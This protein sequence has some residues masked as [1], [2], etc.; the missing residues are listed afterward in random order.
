MNR[1]EAAGQVIK[2][3]EVTRD[4]SWNRRWR[5]RRSSRPRRRRGL[6]RRCRRFA[7][8]SPVHPEKFYREAL[9]TPSEILQTP[10]DSG[11]KPRDFSHHS[12]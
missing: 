6:R 7:L 1:R 11:L 12:H 2:P 4:V 5:P 9:G 10:P 8:G 3:L